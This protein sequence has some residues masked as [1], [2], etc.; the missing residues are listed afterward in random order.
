PCANGTVN[1]TPGPVT[2]VLTI[3]GNSRL[4]QLGRRTRIDIALNA[5]PAGPNPASYAIYL[6]PNERENQHELVVGGDTLGCTV[7]P[8]PFDPGLSP[9]PF[10]CLKGGLGPEYSGSVKV[11]NISPATAPWT[12][13]KPGGFPRAIT[14][15]L[16]GVIEDASS[17]S[18]K[19]VTNAVTLIIR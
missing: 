11:M 19:S 10:K 2:D 1:A 16:Q 12:R 7:N 4:V 13:S 3:N 5:A 18:G 14:L 8:T 17:P 15:T 9:Q 6:H